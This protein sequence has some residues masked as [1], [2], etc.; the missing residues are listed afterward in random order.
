MFA[1]SYRPGGAEYAS[2]RA[3]ELLDELRIRV[4]ECRLV[5]HAL[6]GEADMKFDELEQDLYQVQQGA[7]LAYQA[8]SMVHQG[9]ALNPR[10]GVG[11]SRPK[12]I[13]ARHN[14]AVHDGADRLL[15]ECSLWDRLERALSQLPSVE[16]VS[17]AIGIPPRCTGTIRATGLPCPAAAIRLDDVFCTHCYSHASSV[18]REKYRKDR[19]AVATAQDESR[20]KLLRRRRTVAEGIV[21]RWLANRVHRQLWVDDIEAADDSR[22]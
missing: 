19:E 11:F 17:D 10:W 1:T 14:A 5:L 15:P 22:G 3:L 2:D 20:E 16:A 12:A 13:F 21:D 9:A 6:P 4:M 18:E 7:H 8:A